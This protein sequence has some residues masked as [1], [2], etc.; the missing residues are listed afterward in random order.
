MML[1]QILNHGFQLTSY[2]KPICQNNRSFH[3]SPALCYQTIK[4]RKRYP[5]FWLQDKYRAYYDENLT[6]ENE[7]FFQEFLKNK[8]SGKSPLKTEPWNVNQK[9]QQGF[10]RT[11]LIGIKLGQFP[12]WTKQGHRLLTTCVKVSD[13]HVVKYHSPEEYARIGRPVDRK[14]YAGKG[15]IIVGADSRDP[16]QFSAEYNGLFE[17]GCV[18]PKKKLT[19]FFISH[20]SRIEP[21]TPLMASHFRPGM[22]VD[23]YGKSKEWGL[24]GVR[25]RFKLKLG[26]KTHGCTKAHNRIG[27]IGRGRKECGPKKGRRMQGHHG[28]ER[29]VMPGLKVWR[30]DT[31]YNLIYLHG[32]AIPGEHGAYINI[33]DSRMPQKTLMDLNPP[34]FPTTTMD[35]HNALPE[36]LY[37]NDIHKSSDPS[38]ILEISEEERKAAALL[39]KTRVTAKT[40]QKVR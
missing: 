21:G 10:S 31:K 29:V 20:E 38:I 14:R 13:N 24:Q 6:P 1:R 30:I 26:P 37:D 11:G 12:M 22:Y 4:R 27:S 5:F 36:E 28:G 15:C 8:Y 25:F 2:L 7:Q 17:E 34:P 40:A 23:I 3:T 9:Y 19:R 35:E 32:P 18:M 16:R 33:M 39:A